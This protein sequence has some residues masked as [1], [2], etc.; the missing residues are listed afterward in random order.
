[1]NADTASTDGSKRKNNTLIGDGDMHM[2]I[3]GDSIAMFHIRTWHNRLQIGSQDISY[4]LHSHRDSAAKGASISC[5][6]TE[7]RRMHPIIWGVVMS[8]VFGVVA[9]VKN[10]FEELDPA[11]QAE[12]R[13]AGSVRAAQFKKF[14]GRLV[15]CPACTAQSLVTGKTVRSTEPRLED[16][17]ILQ[18]HVVLP[19]K[20]ECFSCGLTLDD[21]AKLHVLGIGGQYTATEEHDPVEFHHIDPADYFEADYGNE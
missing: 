4:F 12:K 6:S 21:H 14:W 8:L 10:E 16:E 2:K 18:D 13:N 20:L 1:M 15:A 3:G 9:A 19:T 7:G 5:D 11:M 17:L